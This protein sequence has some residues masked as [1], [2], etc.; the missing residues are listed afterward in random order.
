V[1]GTYVASFNMYLA[2]GQEGLDIFERAKIN[3]DENQWCIPELHRIRGE[4]APTNKSEGL[5]V[6]RRYFHR[7]LEL[8]ARQASLSWALWA[9]ISLA[10]AKGQ[11]RRGE[12]R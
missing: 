1:C 9:A 5:A 11:F 6:S 2:S 7:A 4:L 10:I 12:V 8:S 3:L